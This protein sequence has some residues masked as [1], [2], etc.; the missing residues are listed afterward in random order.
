MNLDDQKMSI[1]SAAHA[2]PPACL[3]ACLC[4]SHDSVCV[5]QLSGWISLVTKNGQA[6]LHYEQT[7]L[8]VLPHII[9][10]FRLSDLP[11]VPDPG[12][13]PGLFVTGL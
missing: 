10:P 4:V 11:Y 9:D 13:P 6:A 2:V 5:C 3:R 12:R 1:M 7:R 8:P